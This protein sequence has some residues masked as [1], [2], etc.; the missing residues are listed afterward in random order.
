[1]N[2]CISCFESHYLKQIILTNNSIGN[3]DFCESKNINIY[4][5]EE[6][7]VFFKGLLDLYE[8][9]AEKGDLIETQI[10]QDFPEKVFT[11]ILIVKNNIKALLI[12]IMSEDSS[13]Y[14]DILSKPVI[15][16]FYKTDYEERIVK[17]LVFSWE[18]FSQEIKS[19]NRFHF[20]NNL[21]LEKLKEKIFIAPESL[22]TQ[23]DIQFHKWVIRQTI[24][25]VMV[26]Q[27]QK[28]FPI[29]IY[30]MILKQHCLK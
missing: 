14:E 25:Q 10:L 5:A 6:L 3:C 11:K 15:L 18:K 28:A 20:Q 1:M 22:Q 16:K 17:P 9:D 23:K 24:K 4:N 29:C 13:D 8:V 27:T 30:L 19:V 26:E 2:C 21:D 12:S 7:N